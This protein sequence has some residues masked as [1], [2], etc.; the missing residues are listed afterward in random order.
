[1]ICLGESE[2]LYLY[3][4][5]GAGTNEKVLIEILCSRT[6]EEIREIV[7][8]YKVEFN[9]NLEKD[10][11][12]DTSGHFKRLLTSMCQVRSVVTNVLFKLDLSK[13]VV[14]IFLGVTSEL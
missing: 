11:C 3:L 7:R 1:M 2:F 4:F 9:R 6:N 14:L 13:N 5:Q 8:C 12:S 10:I